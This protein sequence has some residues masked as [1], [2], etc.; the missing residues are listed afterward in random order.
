MAAN[1][2]KKGTLSASR[3][4]EVA[5]MLAIGSRLRLNEEQR[6][7]IERTVENIPRKERDRYRSEVRIARRM[8][9]EGNND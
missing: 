9:A 7:S 1:R 2:S 6:R 5:T 3:L 4:H 8:M